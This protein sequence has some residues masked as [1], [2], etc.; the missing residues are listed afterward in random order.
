MKKIFRL[1]RKFLSSGVSF[2]W[3]YSYRYH[4]LG[5]MKGTSYKH[6]VLIEYLKKQHAHI[7]GLYS[8]KNNE[9]EPIL[10]NSPIW[11]CW[12]QGKEQMPPIVSACYHSLQQHAGSHPVHLITLQNFHDYVSFPE[13]IIKKQQEG[14]ITFTHF[15]DILRFSLLAQY[16][17]LWI[18][19]T[20]WVTNKIAIT[21]KTFFTLK[22]NRPDDGVYVSKYRWTGFCIGGGVNNLLFIVIRD[23][24]YDY[25]KKNDFVIEYLM[26]DYFIQIVYES[27]IDVKKM[28]DDNPFNNEELYYMHL[29]LNEPFEK[30]IY[31]KICQT[32]YLH[33]LTWKGRLNAF[34][35]T[36]DNSYYGYILNISNVFQA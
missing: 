5:R 4:I 8:H 17:G 33:K 20:V 7:I 36:G 9:S 12:W 30:E 27:N 28:I 6:Q 29:H 15:S 32:T 22:M 31:D 23:L 26:L 19:A 14:K 11:V 35:V 16:G 24:L 18:D 34:T 1:F 25:W 2:G 10:N 21:G 3:K 13:Y